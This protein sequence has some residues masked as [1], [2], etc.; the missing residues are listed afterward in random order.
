MSVDTLFILNLIDSGIRIL[1][2]TKDI[3]SSLSFADFIRINPHISRHINIAAI[4]LI[5]F[6]KMSV[7][8]FNPIICIPPLT[9]VYGLP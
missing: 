5:L 9:D 6:S 1:T 8:N 7:Y 3:N 4:T 2:H